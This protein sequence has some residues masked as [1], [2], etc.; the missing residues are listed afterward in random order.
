MAHN[1]CASEVQRAATVAIFCAAGL[2]L[3]KLVLFFFSGSLVIAMS[4]W[5]SSLDFIVSSINRKI[6]QYARQ[7]ADDDHPYGHGRAESIAAFGQGCLILGGGLVVFISSIYD[8]INF[9]QRSMGEKRMENWGYVVFFLLATVVSQLIANLLKYKGKKYNSMA[10]IA[11]AKHYQVDSLTNIASAIGVAGVIFFHLPILD[12]I[13]AALFAIYV[14][15]GGFDLLR[16][17]IKEL[18][19]HVLPQDVFQHVSSLVQSV[20]SRIIDI[21]KLRGRKMGHYYHF[22]F[23][24]SLPKELTFEEVHGVLQKIERLLVQH[25][26]GDTT[27]HADPK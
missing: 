2:A 4:A 18:M 7:A 24:L 25:Y 21:H 12:P 19:D 1:V 16:M 13:I 10:L 14:V 8:I 17:S 11:D 26:G 5:D 23:H 6:I 27:I 20:D 22:D 9:F 3:T 15:Y